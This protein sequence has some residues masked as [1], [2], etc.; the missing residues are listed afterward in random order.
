MRVNGVYPPLALA[1]AFITDD[2]HTPRARRLHPIIADLKRRM[3]LATR[4]NSWR[5]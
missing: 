5:D 1:E 3:G 4:V 2:D